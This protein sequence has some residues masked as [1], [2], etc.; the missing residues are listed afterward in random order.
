M[1]IKALATRD[2]DALDWRFVGLFFLLRIIFAFVS[3]V[4]TWILRR[5]E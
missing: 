3:I 1:I 5:H 2:L 4:E